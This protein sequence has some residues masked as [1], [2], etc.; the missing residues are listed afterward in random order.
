[1]IMEDPSTVWAVSVHSEGSDLY[2]LSP[3]E[4]KA[5][6][7]VIGMLAWHFLVEDLLKLIP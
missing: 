7:L 4:T 5:F 2:T 1:M 6:G 3:F